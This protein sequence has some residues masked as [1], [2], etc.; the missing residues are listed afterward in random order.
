M[1]GFYIAQAGLERLAS[2]PYVPG[3]QAWATVAPFCLIFNTF[4]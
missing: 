4:Q 1:R 2:A 3:P